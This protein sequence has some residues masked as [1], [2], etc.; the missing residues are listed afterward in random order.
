MIGVLGQPT[1][2]FPMMLAFQRD[3]T[4]RV[5]LANIRAHIPQLAT[6]IEHNRLDPRPIISHTLELAEVPR[7]YQIFDAR[8]EGAIKILIKP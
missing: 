4:F 6:L 3:L 8:T 7:G 2:N 5:G 1:Y